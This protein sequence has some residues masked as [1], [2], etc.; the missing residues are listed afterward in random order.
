[1]SGELSAAPASPHLNKHVVYQ[2]IRLTL[3]IRMYDSENFNYF[4]GGLGVEDITI[5]QNVSLIQALFSQVSSVPLFI[6]AIQVMQPF[7]FQM[8]NIIRRRL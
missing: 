5:G 2:F 3:G 1:M 6:Q 7:T 4:A 8:F